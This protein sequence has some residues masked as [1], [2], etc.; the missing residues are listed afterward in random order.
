[1]FEFLKKKSLLTDVDKEE[2]R[3]IKRKAY[4]EEARKIMEKKGQELAKKEL[5]N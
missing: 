1:M 4:I 2:L 3:E 5:S